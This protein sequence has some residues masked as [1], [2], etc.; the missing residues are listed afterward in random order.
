MSVSL[1]AVIVNEFSPT[2][3]SSATMRTVLG[4]SAGAKVSFL[5]SAFAAETANTPSPP[6]AAKFVAARPVPSS[7]R[8]P[9]PPVLAKL[10]AVSVSVK[11]RTAVSSAAV[12]VTLIF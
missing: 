6:L 3:S 8:T 1:K 2:V 5:Y 7:F 9:T 12:V 11:R 10:M 4:A